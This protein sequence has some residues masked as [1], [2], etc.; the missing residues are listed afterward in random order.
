[1]KIRK[2]LNRQLYQQ[3]AYGYEK[4]PY[5]FDEAVSAAILG[6][7][8]ETLKTLIASGAIILSTGMR[9]LSENEL[10]IYAELFT[11]TLRRDLGQIRDGN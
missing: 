11:Y 7:D 5:Y 4:K 10:K 2:E 6:G 3:K 1:M 8:V 9:S